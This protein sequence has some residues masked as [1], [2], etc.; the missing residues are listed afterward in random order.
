[1]TGGCCR[2]WLRE[3][4][5]CY[6]GLPSQ[7][8]EEPMLIQLVSAGYRPAAFRAE[9]AEQFESR[10]AYLSTPTLLYSARQIQWVYY[11]LIFIDE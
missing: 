10:S 3:T 7:A 4:P 9:L 8:V 1:M 5:I 6:M 11:G 2:C